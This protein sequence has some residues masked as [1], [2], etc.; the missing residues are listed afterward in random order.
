[1]R[2]LVGPYRGGVTGSMMSEI[3]EAEARPGPESPAHSLPPRFSWLWEARTQLRF[4][5]VA[6]GLLI[7]G[8]ILHAGL[9]WTV[10]TVLIWISLGLGMVYGVRAAFE[11]LAARRVDIDV[12][13]VVG[14][15][16]AASIGHP[17]EGSLLLFLFTLSGALEELAM[18]RTQR[19]IEA[20]HKLLPTETLVWKGET[21]VEIAPEALVAG[22]RVKV[23]PGERV[24]TDATVVEGRSSLDQSTL[25][26]ESMPRSV[27]AGDAIYAGTVNIDG[28]LEATVT[29]P[30]ADSSLQR[31]LN[32]VMQARE[33]REPMQRLIDR[34]G[35]PYAWA[36]LSLSAVVMLVWWLVFKEPAAQAAYTAITFLIVLSPCA[37]IIATPTATLSAIGRGARQGVLFKGGQAMERLAHVGAVCFD[38]TG[39]LTFGRPSLVDVQTIGWSDPKRLLG[40]AAGL[41][42]DSTHPIASAVRGGASSR[43]VAP[44]R[45]ADMRHIAGSGV[46]GVFES[47]P[48]AVGSLEFVLDTVPMCLRAR[49]GEIVAE[50]QSRGQM[51]AVVAAGGGHGAAAVL[52]ISDSLRPGADRMASELHEM[53]IRPVR[54]LTGDNQQAAE[55]IARQVGIDECYAD[56][57]P[58]DKL[59]LVGQ[60]KEE[61]RARS[62]G[63]GAVAFIGDGV[64]DAPAMAMADVSVAIG[65]IGSDAALESADIVLLNDDLACVPWAIGLARRA[66]GILRFNLAMAMSV[67]VIMAIVTLVGSRTGLTVP[68]AVGVVAHE[69]G[70]LAVVA[71]SLRLLLARGVRASSK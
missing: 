2:V 16:L 3:R 60:L 40:V 63:R 38:K 41:E 31:V 58:E 49:A 36:V 55:H 25:T 35:E 17:G 5:M 30:A 15:G 64:N 11:A 34:F 57:L 50:A 22:D 53:G 19:E 18:A 51:T 21:W 43:G 65:S 27:Q 56:L 42:I 47:D 37:M 29:R 46:T 33:Q 1:M 26:G 32:L 48:V 23:R 10:G 52:V 24:P 8:T 14:A 66:R 69:G 70:T 45:I 54:M 13:M 6:G 67:I 4:S 20:L 44:E 68:M 9:G 59:R 71:N 61:V 39:T 28:A 62:R 12:L 7:L